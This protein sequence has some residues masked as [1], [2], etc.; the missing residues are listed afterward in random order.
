[1][2]RYIIFVFFLANLFGSI[3]KNIIIDSDQELLIELEIFPT[4]DADLFPSYFFIGLPSDK[5]PITEV[6]FKN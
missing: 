5:L 6:V 3:N 1:M 4:T 2:I